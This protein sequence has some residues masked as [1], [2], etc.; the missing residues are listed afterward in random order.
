M[1]ANGFRGSILAKDHGDEAECVV[2][3]E[4]IDYIKMEENI[5]KRRPVKIEI[6]AEKCGL[7]F[8]KSVKNSREI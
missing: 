6:Q 5:A 2:D 4:P 7:N 1:L 3:V 8:V